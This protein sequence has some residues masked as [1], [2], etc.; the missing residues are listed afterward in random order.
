MYKQYFPEATVLDKP[1]PFELLTI[2]GIKFKKA[3]TLFSSAA[4]NLPAQTELAWYGTSVH[5]VLEE[6]LGE[7]MKQIRPMCN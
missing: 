6:K 4:F 2:M 7:C 1:L 3:I 5:P